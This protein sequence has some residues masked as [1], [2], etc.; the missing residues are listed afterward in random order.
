MLIVG[1]G[2][3]FLTNVTMH[4]RGYIRDVSEMV[5]GKPSMTQNTPAISNR[6]QREVMTRASNSS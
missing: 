1:I 5:D 4:I 3:Y 6:S 2:C